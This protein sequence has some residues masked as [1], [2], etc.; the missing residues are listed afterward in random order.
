VAPFAIM[1][2]LHLSGPTE[3]IIPETIADM[4]QFGLQI[5]APGHCTGWRA[6]SAMERTFGDKVVPL[7]VGKR[8]L[9]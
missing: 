6:I 4:E 7:A 2:G 8:F 1:G 5:F 9:V 3:V